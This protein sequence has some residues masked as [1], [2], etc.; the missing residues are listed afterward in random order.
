MTS[1]H[2]R[3]LELSPLLDKSIKHENMNTN[4]P[5]L[6]TDDYAMPWTRRDLGTDETIYKE[7]K[8]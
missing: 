6:S 4:K 1:F 2:G 5:L 7:Y 3:N 8:L